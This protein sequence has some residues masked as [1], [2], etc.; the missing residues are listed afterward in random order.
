MKETLFSTN[1]SS[2]CS[3]ATEIESWWKI[4][5][6]LKILTALIYKICMIT[7]TSTNTITMTVLHYHSRSNDKGQI[8]KKVSEQLLTMDGWHV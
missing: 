3:T 5:P 4:L 7:I 1:G 8:A 2:L 6:A